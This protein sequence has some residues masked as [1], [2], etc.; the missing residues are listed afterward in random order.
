MVSDTLKLLGSVL[1][2]NGVVSA[3]CPLGWAKF[4]SAYTCSIRQRS[5]CNDTFFDHAKVA[6]IHRVSAF[7]CRQPLVLRLHSDRSSE[8]AILFD[9]ITMHN[10][11][12]AF[13]SHSS[14]HVSLNALL[15]ALGALRIVPHRRVDGCTMRD[16]QQSL[17]QHYTSHR[18]PPHRVWCG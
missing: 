16:W 7:E 11:F 17:H 14:W 5:Q 15:E 10:T 13:R 6:Y 1:M 18:T 8:R 12:N 3:R 9:S 2:F 4:S